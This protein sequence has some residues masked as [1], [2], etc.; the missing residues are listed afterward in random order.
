VRLVERH[1]AGADVIVADNY[2]E[3]GAL[4]LFG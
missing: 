1:A 4:E 2:G 3:A